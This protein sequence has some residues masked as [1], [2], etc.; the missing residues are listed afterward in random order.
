MPCKYCGTHQYRI[1]IRGVK[2]CSGCGAEVSPINP[3]WCANDMNPVHNQ[4]VDL[5]QPYQRY[6]GKDAPTPPGWGDYNEFL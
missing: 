3:M 4:G 5:E 2:E 6:Y 1:S